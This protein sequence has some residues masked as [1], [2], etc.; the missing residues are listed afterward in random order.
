MS[1]RVLLERWQK[2][3]DITEHVRNFEAS[4]ASTQSCSHNILVQLSLLKATVKGIGLR[5]KIEVCSE[6]VPRLLTL[7]DALLMNQQA[8]LGGMVKNRL[9]QPRR[10][11]TLMAY[12]SLV[13]NGKL[14]LTRHSSKLNTRILKR[15]YYHRVPDG[16]LREEVALSLL[17]D[18]ETAAL[19]SSTSRTNLLASNPLKPTAACL[20][21]QN[22]LMLIEAYK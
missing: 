19:T 8:S 13:L 1:H 12:F 4:N 3:V 16:L 7:V 15:N 18:V 14:T 10:I 2:F 21:F 6:K 5:L 20:F 22:F 9:M 17:S 11:S